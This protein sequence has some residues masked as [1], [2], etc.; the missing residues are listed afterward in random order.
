MV[1]VE[2][3]DGRVAIVT[4]AARGIGRAIAEGL[5]S[6]G[7][8]VAALD[9]EAP[10]LPGIVGY[11]CDV[12]DEAAVDE[13]ITAIEGDL[14]VVAVAVLNAGV[15]HIRPF[16][17]TTTELWERTLAVNLTG[18]FLC[19][20]RVLRGMR[21]GGWGRIIMIS[22]MAGKNGA[23]KPAAAYAASKAGM[24][25]LARSIA[26]EYAPYG[27]T[28]NAIAPALIDTPMIDDARDLEK[29]IPVGRLGTPQDVASLACYLASEEASF[30][31][32]EVSDVNGG[33]YID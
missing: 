25:N 17:E 14:G 5:A 8:M 32:G 21:E 33:V 1:R 10:D 26:R 6:N 18:A 29:L 22:S 9:L 12:S 23:I 2:G 24:S 13:A 16:E 30:I 11:A 19:A 27:V 31:T 28:A 4:G 7:A 20:R 3:L 15:F